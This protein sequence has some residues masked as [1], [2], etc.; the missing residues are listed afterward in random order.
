[1]KFGDTSLVQAR[2]KVGTRAS[3][4][5]TDA[6]TLV[7]KGTATPTTTLHLRTIGASFE[8]SA[9]KA[10]VGAAIISLA[11]RIANATNR[12]PIWGSLAGTGTRAAVGA[13]RCLAG[14]SSP[15]SVANANSFHSAREGER[16]ATTFNAVR[17]HRARTRAP[18][19]IER[20]RDAVAFP[21]RASAVSEAVLK[22]GP[23][24]ITARENR[25]NEGRDHRREKTLLV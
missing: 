3:V 8:K 11:T 24:S 18:G 9:G 14:I 5:A 21:V 12:G 4:R 16:R 6:L 13:L 15:S 1:M 22:A 19:L 7:R 2:E 25:F 17:I 10:S 23:G 20:G